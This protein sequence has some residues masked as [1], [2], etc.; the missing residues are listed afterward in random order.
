MYA[1]IESSC[2]LDIEG[3]EVGNFVLVLIIPSIG[4]L[5]VLKVGKSV[6]VLIR[7]LIIPFPTRNP[8]GEHPGD[9]IYAYCAP[10]YLETNKRKQSKCNQIT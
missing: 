6:L 5:E 10:A 2:I 8:V 9:T 1:V 4:S 3:I 7:I